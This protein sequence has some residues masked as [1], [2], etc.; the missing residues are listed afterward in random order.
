MDN[1]RN[2]ILAAVLSLA[3]VFFWQM[4]VITPR[5]ERE[6]AIVEQQ[7][8]EQLALDKANG[9]K[10][11][12]SDGSAGV[13]ASSSS[14]AS[15]IPG[16][17]QA[18]PAAD[19]TAG[20]VPLLSDKLNGSINLRGARLDDL[21]L[22]SYH[23]EVDKS[24]PEISLLN[25]VHKEEAYF[26]EFGW[27][28]DPAVGK[29]PGPSTVWKLVEG[30]TLSPTSSVVLEYTNDKNIAFRRTIEMDDKYMFT[31]SETVTNASGGPVTI[32]PYGRIARYGKPK[33]AGIYVLHEGMVGYV[34]DQGLDEIDYG[35][36][37]DDKKVVKERAKKGW[38]G[39]TDKYWATA[40]IPG[41]AFTARYNYIS[42]GR[43][44]YQSDF[45]GDGI[46]IASGGVA[47]ISNQLF[48]GAKK[49]D[50][51]DGYANDLKIEKFDLLIDW[52]WFYFITKPMFKVMNWIYQLVGNFGV[53]I[54]AV[55]VL[56]KLLFFPLANKS[57]TSMAKMKKL[58]PEMTSIRERLGD[59]KPAQQKAMME[60][61]KKEKINP[62]AGCWPMLIQIPVFFSLYKVIYVTIEMRHAPFFGWIQDLSAPDPTSMLNLFGLLPFESPAFLAIIA[63]G[64]WPLIMG[65]TMFVQMQMNPAPPDPT[66]QMIFKWMP[67]M[68]T[69]MLATFPAGLV[70]YWAWNNTLSVLQQGAIM[71]RQ[72]VKI[73][74]WDNLKDMFTKKK[75]EG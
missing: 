69:F 32:K 13:P 74:L 27:S 9:V 50:I 22:S 30:K 61:Y 37:E 1:Q 68:F 17:S 46:T 59:D 39:I 75:A 23:E 65:I 24:S 71:K 58:Q 33:V 34:G 67:I 15:T 6:R 3:V 26:A 64:V 45:L 47:K 53:A 40:I 55:T 66:Q 56:L 11:A 14:Q 54:L 44:F 4:F 2:F 29:L 62:A 38:L 72:G 10:P 48:A 41:N 7:A 43:P 63:V 36:I 31:I 70:I 8:A 57:Y 19:E 21:R 51:V 35:E 49:V 25:P 60:L 73:E 42:N 16:A 20:R 52:G 12:A 18:A 5:I 28:P